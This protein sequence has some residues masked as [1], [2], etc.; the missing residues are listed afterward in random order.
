M[1]ILLE[2]Q[3]SKVAYFLKVLQNFTFVKNATPISNAKA[4]LMLDIKEAVEE[5]K[6]VRK[7]KLEARN[8]EDIIDEL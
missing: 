8:A 7:G 6:L 1:K 5:L 4:N 2:I 3:D